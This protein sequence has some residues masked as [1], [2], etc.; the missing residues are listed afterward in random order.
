MYGLTDDQEAE[1]FRSLE[2]RVRWHD[3]ILSRMTDTK[4]N[5]PEYLDLKITLKTLQDGLPGYHDD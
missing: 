1:A 2:N 4:P 5:S 3:R